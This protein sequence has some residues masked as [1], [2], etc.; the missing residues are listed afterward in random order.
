MRHS[1]IKVL[2]EDFVVHEEVDLPLEDSGPHRVYLME[3][4]SWNTMDA[5]RSIA[6]AS[7]IA[8]AMVRYAG[9]KDRHALTYQ[10]LSVP[11]GM[12]LVSGN[13]SVKLRFL[14]FSH[15]FVSTKVLTGNAFRV[16]L[17][18]LSALEQDAVSVRVPEVTA[19][20]FPNYYDDQRFGSVAGEGFFAERLLRGHLRGALKIHLTSHF[21]NDSPK[22]RE[23]KTK[24]AASWGKWDEVRDLCV[25]ADE[26]AVAEALRKGGR[27]NDLLL[28]VNAIPAAEA[29]IYLSAYQS[30]LWNKVLGI[31]LGPHFH[32]HAFTVPGKMGGYRF[33]RSLSEKSL[34]RLLSL[35]VP[36]VARRLLPCDAEVQEAIETVLAEAGIPLSA[37]GLRGVRN[38]Y[39][40]SFHRPAIVVPRDLVSSGVS[41]DD[42]YPG[43]GKACLEF[44]LPAGS[45]ATMLI[46][47]VVGAAPR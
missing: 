39:F 22:E 36:T 7:G 46:K 25:T 5:V 10:H 13:P 47:A 21:P 1:K 23:R 35:Q 18:S 30:H 14:G 26:I 24:V 4:R 9:L 37:F 3:K 29:A 16:T 20:G 28:G 32:D 45:Y 38:A 12:E 17:R 11:A 27:R 31:L 33:Y 34:Q 40:H 43:T 44:R 8:P 2:P 42:R 15:D 41:P 19:F 6:E